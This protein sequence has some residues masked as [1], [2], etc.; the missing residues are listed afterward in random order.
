M[1]VEC[2]MAHFTL[3]EMPFGIDEAATLYHRDSQIYVET[4]VG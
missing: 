3:N 4:D 2:G 1:N